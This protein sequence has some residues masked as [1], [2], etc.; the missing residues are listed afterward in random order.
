M[1]GINIKNIL[2]DKIGSDNGI[3]SRVLLDFLKVNGALL[4][5]IFKSKRGVSYGFINLPDDSVLINKIKKFAVSQKKKQW[6]NIVVLGIGGSALGGIALRDAL[7]GQYHLLDKKPHLFFLDNID[8]DPVVQLLNLIK[9]EKSLFIII[10]K[11]GGTVEPMALYNAI[12]E[13]LVKAKIKDFKKNLIFITD[14]KNGLLR[15]AGEKEKIYMFDVPTKVGGRFSVLSS[16][17]LVPAALAGIDIIKLM[18][19]AKKMREIIK[20]TAPIKN[21]A[22]ILATLQFMMDCKKNKHMTVMMPYS[23]LLF[24]LGDWYRQLLAESIGKNINTG[25]TPINALG[26]T[27]QHSQLQLYNEGPDDKWFIFLRVL[28]HKSDIK[29]GDSSPEKIAF[30]NGK[31][32]SSIL[33]AAY[34]GT[35]EALAKN[36]RPNITLDIPEVNAETLGGLFMLFEFQVALLGS[37]YKVDAFNQPGVEKS[38]QLTKEILSKKNNE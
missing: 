23:N 14:P 34:A 2:S 35:S 16:V 22:L 38:K 25:P 26:T 20:K 19:G 18:N 3:N 9:L 32:M 11:S 17:G 4:D 1:I 5:E 8:P 12:K 7:L 28:K 31:K 36:K 24:R 30:L 21:P 10:S 29:L 27:D 37:L 6:E 33:D 13:R 15:T